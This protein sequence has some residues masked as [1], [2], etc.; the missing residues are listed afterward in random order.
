VNE[1]SHFEKNN[2]YVR[3]TLLHNS[4][5]FDKIVNETFY[6]Q[7]AFRQKKG[8]TTPLEVMNRKGLIHATRYVTMCFDRRLAADCCRE[9]VVA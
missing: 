3:L 8:D 6:M 2:S 7:M 5:Q 1:I 9:M 4:F